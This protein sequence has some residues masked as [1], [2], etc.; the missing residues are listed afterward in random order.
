MKFFPI[1]HYTLGNLEITVER[2]LLVLE[3]FHQF[4][5]LLL[6]LDHCNTDI[7]IDQLVEAVYSLT[8]RILQMSKEEETQIEILVNIF[9]S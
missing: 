3:L 9:F 5:W 7:K 6:P 2:T 4:L 1:A 8:T